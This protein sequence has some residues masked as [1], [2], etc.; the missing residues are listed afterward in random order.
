MG[1]FTADL[2]GLGYSILEADSS[3][4]LFHERVHESDQICWPALLQHAQHEAFPESGVEGSLH[5]ERY[6]GGKQR[7]RKQRT[8]H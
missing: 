8:R 5:V 6:Y 7:V 1:Q 3:P 2:L 4:A